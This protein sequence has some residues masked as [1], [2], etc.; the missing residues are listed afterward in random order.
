MITMLMLKILGLVTL[1][2]SF[3]YGFK[4][5]FEEEKKES[6]SGLLVA[7]VIILG[8]MFGVIYIMNN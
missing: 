5:W 8:A 2:Y 6:L 7:Y 4:K 3:F 1:V